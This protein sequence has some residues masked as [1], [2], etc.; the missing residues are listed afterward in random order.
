M[1]SPPDPPAPGW[2]AS[3]VRTEVDGPVPPHPHWAPPAPGRPAA[4]LPAGLPLPAVAPVP[5]APP[6]RSRSGRSL[7]LAAVGCLLAALV[8]GLLTAAQYRTDRSPQTVVRHY[9]AALAAGDAAAALGYGQAPPRGGYLT[10]SVLHQQLALARITDLSVQRTE[11]TGTRG[12]V[13]VSYRLRFA[14]GGD[15]RLTDSVPVVR[16]GSSWRLDRVAVMTELTVTTPGADRVTLAGGRLPTKPVLVFPGALPLATDYPAVRVADQPV[17]GLS[18]DQQ[19][20]ELTVVL[21]G[22]ARASLQRS[23]G[24][25]L[26]RCLAGTAKQPGCPQAGDSRPVPGSL[27]GTALPLRQPL[28][29]YLGVGGAVH[30]SGTVPVHGSWQDWDFN[31]QPVRHTGDTDVTVDAIASVA[32]LNTVYWS[33]S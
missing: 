23:L 10:D 11:L 22:A 14:A 31:N 1:N 21:T 27:R 12:T 6:R 30:L 20:T 33:S 32:D 4:Q 3:G 18:S 9:F 26:A 29:M 24:T 5:P 15:Q 19:S 28:D 13:S 17:V 8:C 25:A 7:L 16:H 2:L